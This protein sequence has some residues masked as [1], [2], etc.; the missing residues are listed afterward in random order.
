MVKAWNQN[1][2]Q[3]LKASAESMYCPFQKG[4]E[5]QLQMCSKQNR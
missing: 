5:G 1:T 3:Y 4:T 2:V